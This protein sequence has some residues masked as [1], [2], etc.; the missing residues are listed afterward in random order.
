MDKNKLRD[1]LATLRRCIIEGNVEGAEEVVFECEKVF[2]LSF[3]DRR[4]N[5]HMSAMIKDEFSTTL[6]PREAELNNC[7]ALKT[8]GNG[9]CM[10]NAASLLLAGNELLS[11][12]IRLLVA[13]E[14]FFFS[15]HYIQTFQDTFLEIENET[16]YSEA[17]VF[18]TILTEAGAKEMTNSKNR[19]EAIRAEARDT[20]LT[21]NWNGMVQLMALSTVLRWPI[22][23]V[24]PEAN[25]ALRPILHW[26]IPPRRAEGHDNPLEQIQI[27]WSRD[28]SLDSR[29]HDFF[30]PN[31]F[32]PVV[33]V[34]DD[35]ATKEE[36]NKNKP[37]AKRPSVEKNMSYF[38]KPA[39]VDKVESSG[40]KRKKAESETPTT[41]KTK[42]RKFL[43]HWKDDFPWIVYDDEKGVI[44][45]KYCQQFGAT[46]TGK[47][48]FV[49]SCKTFK[50]ETMK[51]HNQ[52][53]THI[54][55]CDS[56]MAKQKAVE[57]RPIMKSFVKT[58]NKSDEE[59]RND[60]AKKMNTA[61]F[62]AKEELPFTKFPKLLDLQRKNGL[63]IGETYSTDKKCAE[64]VSTISKVY[65]N[66]LAK[67]VNENVKYMSIMIDGGEDAG[68]VEN[69]TIHCRLVE[70]GQPVN[71][72]VGHKAIEHAHAESRCYS[73]F[74]ANVSVS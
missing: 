62:V 53:F 1:D 38:F 37:L 70:H 40:L 32:V 8:T 16:P 61:Y 17:T 13:G 4:V 67:T 52:S 51:K 5:Y 12:V 33:V 36:T 42:S 25:P 6:I 74:E 11:D 9:N 14:L 49:T 44:L 57:D 22:F 72:L 15:E 46:T 7:I 30:Q 24:Y 10:F 45:C 48:D 23:S 69:A 20:C 27:M 35:V 73:I 63:Q 71:H 50:P 66:K 2:K 59:Q 55:S 58:S 31:H 68:G 47:S 34:T 26:T 60:V 29:P 19:L 41:A 56:F 65:Q 3:I 28:G 43:P 39:K 64:M 54:R 21:N 18:S